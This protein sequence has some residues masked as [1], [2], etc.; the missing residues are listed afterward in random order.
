MENMIE[1]KS[2]QDLLVTKTPILNQGNPEEKR[3]EILNYFR[4]TWEL[5]EL[6]YDC[7]N[8][9]EAFLHRAD[10]LRHPL[11]FYFGHTA[12]FFVNKLILAGIITDRLNPKFE[13]MFAV[14]VD[15]MS[16]DDLNDKHYEW[17]TA[18]ETLAY[19]NEAKKMI[20]KLILE[21]P[22]TIPINWESQFWVIMMGIEHQRIHIE[23]SS[24]LIR[25]LPIHLV[26]PNLLFKIC[27]EWG[28]A[29]VNE[30]LKVK[31][32]KVRIGKGKDN[33]LY[34]WDNE[35]GEFQSKIKSF[36]AS[37]FLVSNEEFKAFVDDDGYKTEKWWTEEGWGWVTYKKCEHPL[38]WL[39]EGS[40]WK[41]RTM[42]EMIEMPW[43]WP[44]EVNYLE[45]KAFCNWKSAK[46]GK[47]LRLP[48]EAEYYRLRDSFNIADQP[49]WE[50]APGNINLEYYSSSCPVDKF[51]TGGFYD[52]IGN[53][54]QWTEMPI[55]GLDGFEIHPFYDDFSTPTFDAKHNL[56]KGGSWIS[57]GNLAIRDSRYAFRRHFFQHA[58]FRY[59][60]SD[61]EVE[62]ET[63]Y[64]ETD[65]LVSQYCEFQ[66]GEEYF[67]VK[68]YSKACLA[69]IKDHLKGLTKGNALDIGCATGRTTFEL[70]KYFDKVT[71]LDFSARFIRIGTQLKE[72][73]KLKY[74]RQE[75]G[76]L[77]SHQ[78]I[79]LVDHDLG[80]VRDS[81]E[82][83]QAD[84]CNLKPIYSGYD[85]VFAGNLI[86]RLYDPI[87]FLQDIHMRIN[88]G[89]ILVLTSPY[90]WLEE[91]TEVDKWVGGYRKD[92]EPFTSFDGLKN[93]LREHFDLLDEPRDVPFVIRE[94]SRKFQHTI[95]QMTIWRKK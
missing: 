51:E 62:I 2:H 94:T 90:T 81:V 74:I 26:K 10:P 19:R 72:S 43:N 91:F 48:T 77:T 65:S 54:W 59:I 4:K 88:D 37:K 55:S 45:A 69:L 16:W 71:G 53:V 8:G 78:E 6:L 9:Q 79:K 82:F 76:K 50:M 33:A 42:L 80:S 24:V 46:T 3:K 58:G 15:E 49:E 20:E 21:L 1:T 66:Y 95:A 70:A 64:Y 17:P 47:T 34:G 40:E 89:G 5:D 68:D 60:E 22:L 92:G 27:M 28:D 52:V 56:I 30:L 12:T 87:K 23:T 38:W 25:Q 11:A 83:F 18:Q 73:G 63:D 7:L 39:K 32:G 85:L 35:F 13:S 67:G 57:T 93:I 86:D 75:E 84:A 44:V 14:G 31:S 41:L 29:P 36:H 61:Q